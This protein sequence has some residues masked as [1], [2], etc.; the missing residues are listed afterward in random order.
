MSSGS[1]PSFFASWVRE[2]CGVEPVDERTLLDRFRAGLLAAARRDIG[3]REI[4][5]NDSPEIR[6]WLAEVGINFAA[7]YCAAWICS[8]VRE[9]SVSCGVVRVFGAHEV[10]GP[11]PLEPSP[12]ALRLAYNAEQL[13]ALVRR[14]VGLWPEL[15]PG[16]L[17]F[18]K[19]PGAE[20]TGHV[21]LYES[22][23]RGALAETIE[24][25]VPDQ[26]GREGVVER[27]HIDLDRNPLFLGH[28]AWSRVRLLTGGTP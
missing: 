5:P 14:K 15:E 18:W 24:A 12:A 27:R 8:K 9:A 20:W 2:L 17:L 21:G 1:L 26:R 22:G 3:I 10:I 7:A 25:N 6:G 13:G 23:M 4:R 16:D 28:L 19:R 11:L